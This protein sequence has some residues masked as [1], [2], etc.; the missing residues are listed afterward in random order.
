MET[1][2]PYSTMLSKLYYSE[3][4]E[5]EKKQ[6]AWVQEIPEFDPAPEGI[7]FSALD[8]DYTGQVPGRRSANAIAIPVLFTEQQHDTLKALDKTKD[9]YW[10]ILLPEETATSSKKPLCFYFQAK[11]RLGMN[12]LAVDEMLQE[13]LTLYKSTAVEENKGLPTA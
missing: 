5:G 7:E 1:G 12:T 2:T 13:T 11:M 8:T 4:K 6:V 10:F 3:T 9:Y